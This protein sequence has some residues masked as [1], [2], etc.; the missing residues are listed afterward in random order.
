[1]GS[2][3]KRYLCGCILNRTVQTG[4]LELNIGCQQ[5]AD[6]AMLYDLTRD[7]PYMENPEALVV[8]QRDKLRS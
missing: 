5:H 6:D 2:D 1:M 8:T 3:A 7:I 4:A